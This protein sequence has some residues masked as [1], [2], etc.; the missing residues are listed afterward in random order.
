MCFSFMKIESN[1]VLNYRTRFPFLR[2]NKVRL[3]VVYTI[4]MSG[5]ISWTNLS[6]SEVE[7][8]FQEE[9]YVGDM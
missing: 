6:S 3:L 8:H 1:F 2:R 7:G 5:R 4:S 9:C